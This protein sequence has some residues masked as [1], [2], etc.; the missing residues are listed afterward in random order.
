MRTVQLS[1]FLH[2]IVDGAFNPDHL[3]PHCCSQTTAILIAFLP[4]WHLQDI[5]S[6]GIG[7]VIRRFGAP[8]GD[9]SSVGTVIDSVQS[10]L[11]SEADKQRPHRRAY[12]MLIGNY[13]GH[14]AFATE[15]PYCVAYAAEYQ[16]KDPSKMMPCEPVNH[17]YVMV[18]DKMIVRRLLS[19]PNWDPSERK[20]TKG[21]CLLILRGVQYGP[22]LF[23][24]LVVPRNHAGPLVDSATGHDAPFQTIGSFRAVDPIFP[25]FP[26]D[27]A[28]FTA[29][30][31]AQLKE[32]GVL[33][34]LPMPER[35]PLFPPLV[36]PS[37]SKVVSAAL[38]A[39][40]PEA[41]MEGIEQSLIMDWDEES[42]LSDSY[43]DHHS[44]TADTSIVWGRHLGHSS[45]QKP[46]SAEHLDRDSHRSSDRDHDKNHDGERDKSR[47]GDIRHGSDQ[48]R[49]C[50][51]Q[52][53]GHDD[54]CS[55]TNKHRRSCGHDSSF[56][57]HK[58]KQ[59]H[60][61]STS[62]P[63]SQRHAHTPERQPL[64]PPPMLHSTPLAVSLK[65]ASVESVPARLSF[66]RSQ[67]SLPPLELGEEDTRSLPSGGVPIL[68]ATSSMAGPIPLLSTSASALN[69]TADHTKIIFNLACE[70]LQL[71]ER[72]T[73][74][75]IRLS[76]EEV[77]F[78]T[79][80][81]STSHETLASMRPDHFSTYYQILRS[82]EEPSDARNKAMEEIVN[83]MNRA[84]S[85]ANETLFDHVLDYE[86]KLNVFLDKVGGWIREQEERV[87][88]TVFQ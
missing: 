28:L 11:K 52:C 5:E 55:S 61:T 23:L 46:R 86:R 3:A 39:P 64:P 59:Q 76:S 72:V 27:L 38:G 84:W 2:Y 4:G 6:V 24:E 49:R 21:G 68:A 54:E 31:V 88:T 8:L 1:T 33:T 14:M 17:S 10:V 71:K 36:T 58:A 63:H 69:L 82:N 73:W 9:V 25:G 60:G 43:S 45:E 80:A 83:T 42:I 47:K 15:P 41:K 12:M 13:G 7:C 85:Q 79:Q 56:N 65:P 26:G 62:P 32:L 75:F 40:P 66:D 53:R 51:P 16:D 74:E 48:P 19:M 20:R 18:S 87:W 70:G 22:K 50:S 34:P 30:E 67:C 57:N 37:R 44:S 77:L 29:K 78:R 35:L 81:Q